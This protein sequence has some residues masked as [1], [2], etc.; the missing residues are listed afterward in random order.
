M[1]GVTFIRIFYRRPLFTVCAI[2]ILFMIAGYFLSSHLSPLL[3]TLL[4]AIAAVTVIALLTA[5]GCKTLSP[6][7]GCLL[8][9]AVAVVIPALLLTYFSFG[10][11]M[12]SF[13]QFYDK[14]VTIEGYVIENKSIQANFCTY[15]VMVQR[16]DGEEKEHT[17]T[18]TCAYDSVLDPG[19]SFIAKVTGK[20]FQGK[21]NGFDYRL[22]RA[23]DGVFISYETDD[24]D[25][26]F[27]TGETVFDIRIFF[28]R[29]N[30][31]LS[32]IF[33]SNTD[34]ET[35]SL[36]A[37]LLLGNSE[38]LS[39]EVT[40]GFARTGTSHI[41]A[42]SGTHMTIL[43]GGLMILLKKLRMNH[44]LIAVLLSFCAVFYLLLTGFSVSATRAVIM[45]LVVYLALLLDANADALTSLGIAGALILAFSPCSV[46]DAGFWMSLAA[47]LGLLVYMPGWNTFVKARLETSRR[48][49]V[50]IKR[51]VYK[52]LTAFVACIFS[53]IPLIIVMCIFIRE[54]SLYTVVATVVL[55][56]PSSAL[57]ACSALYLP[58]FKIP[59][60][61]SLLG[62]CLRKLARFMIG[63]TAGLA[64]HEDAVISLNYPFI[65]LI[66]LLICGALLYSMIAKCKNLF[67]SLIPFAA[68]CV[69]AIAAMLAYDLT[70]S[71]QVKT[72][73]LNISSQSDMIVISSDKEVVICDI[74]NGSRDSYDRALEE[75]YEA[76]AT[77]IRAIL[78]TRY[79]YRHNA[80]LTRIFR[81]E[82]VRS[83]WLPYPRNETEYYRMVPL[84]ESAARWGVE[85]Y[86]YQDS[87]TVSPLAT[88]DITASGCYIERSAVPVSVIAIEGKRDSCVYLSPAFN[89]AVLSERI[90][91]KLTKSD[92]IIF[93][94]RGPTTKTLYTV[95]P[96]SKPHL[97]IFADDTR[98]AYFESEGLY[99]ITYGKVED[100][101]DIY[102]EKD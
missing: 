31:R 19:F 86:L 23:A 47:T 99:G 69:L 68:T 88:I 87:E 102:F 13:E 94:S 65:V 37:A 79:S 70:L 6:Y 16:I 75:A 55:A 27:I 7:H 35:G 89:E 84:V 63:F 32:R 40:R 10:I 12:K 83:L 73:Y 24:P 44:K 61:E 72:A 34:E 92:H 22:S 74:G 71:S 66:A 38:L 82:C 56:L 18:L 64:G 76:R 81:S 59:F 57:L 51:V 46:L 98:I 95:P 8:A 54:I 85:V 20:E 101:C 100:S 28:S 39:G 3:L 41:L 14:E 21:Y 42:L 60:F 96:G 5:V 45:L 1:K 93:G 11:K 17:A 58:L 26:L 53:M 67:T 97:V 33:L 52:L 77:E 4:C 15:E 49:T 90:T 43:M 48:S 50:A 78:L 9:A 62:F 25:A 36:S 29:I 91:Q 80:T 2:F 30:D